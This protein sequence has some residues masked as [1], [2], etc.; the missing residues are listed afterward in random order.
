MIAVALSCTYDGGGVPPRVT[1]LPELVP[2]S[3]RET[4]VSVE[5]VVAAEVI[6]GEPAE[7][8]TGVPGIGMTESAPLF[9]PAGL[10][11]PPIPERPRSIEIPPG[12]RNEFGDGSS[13]DVTAPPVLGTKVG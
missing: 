3:N 8:M 9:P 2:P 6:A 10:P 4:P 11:P 1:P 13:S 12:E 5:N 7:L